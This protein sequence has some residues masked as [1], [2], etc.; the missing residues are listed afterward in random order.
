MVR[1]I[2]LL[3]LGLG[4]LSTL[5]GCSVDLSPYGLS[6]NG[7]YGREAY[8]GEPDRGDDERRNW[9]KD[10]AY[11][12]WERKRDPYANSYGDLN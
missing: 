6:F 7:G 12:Q 4:V 10:R 8:Y 2:L 5:S 9:E 11:Y 3:L 1:R